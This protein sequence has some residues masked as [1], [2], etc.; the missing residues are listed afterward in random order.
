MTSKRRVLSGLGALVFACLALVASAL[1]TGAVEQDVILALT[2]G[3]IDI[4]TSSTALPDGDPAGEGTTTFQGTWDDETGDLAG[5]LTVPVVSTV[6]NG[7]PIDLQISQTGG[8]T[9]NVDPTT[10]LGSLSVTATMNI[11]SPDPAIGPLLG[12]TCNVGP[13]TLALDVVADLTATPATF[14]MTA[15]GFT[16]PA[17]AGCGALDSTVNTTLGITGASTTTTSAVLNFAQ[18]NELPPPPTPPPPAP[19]ALPPTPP[20]QPVAAQPTFTG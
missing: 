17:A 14:A 8:G 20:A 10:G 15:D 13:F 7:I 2:G 4:A 9:G 19:P 12:T 5:T 3:S 1:P 16:V 11:S 6:S 18:T